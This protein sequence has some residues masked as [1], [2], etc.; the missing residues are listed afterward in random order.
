[1]RA[2]GGFSGGDRR[3]CYSRRAI[4]AYL[5][6]LE[7]NPKEG[8]AYNNWGN[9]LSGHKKYIKAIEMDRKA[10][11][12]DKKFAAAYYNWGLALSNLK[13]DGE[14][15]V[16]YRKAGTLDPKYSTPARNQ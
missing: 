14:A 9:A 6:A 1:V 5:G 4:E 16:Q 7:I 2:D 13:R 8:L 12:I 3:G 15:A 10:T 11:D